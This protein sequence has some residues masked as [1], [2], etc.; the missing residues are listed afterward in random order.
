M[1]SPQLTKAGW[2]GKTQIIINTAF[3]A[4]HLIITWGKELLEEL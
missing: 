3:C 2:G 1:V 4:S